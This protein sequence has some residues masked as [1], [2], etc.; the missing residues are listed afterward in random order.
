MTANE[1]LIHTFYGSFSKRD[2][3]GMNA[4]YHPDVTFSDPV[5]GTLHGDRAKAMWQ[6]LCA[7]GTDLKIEYSKVWAAGDRGGAHWDASY[8]FNSREVLNRIDATFVFRDGAIVRHDDDFDLRGWAGQALGLPGKVLG[9]TPFF[10]RKIRATAL[11][12]LDAY[13]SRR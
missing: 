13:L 4:C 6:M 2:A 12:G 3:A 7:R 5:F 9:G 10:R 11:K 8:V 1:D